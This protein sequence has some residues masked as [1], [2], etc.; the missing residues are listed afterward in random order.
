MNSGIADTA[1]FGPEAEFF[2]LDDIRFDQTPNAGY[3]FLD[4][5]EGEWNRGRDEG[6]NLGYKVR[7]KEGYFPV[8][9]T[10][11]MMDIRNEMMQTLIDCGLA[12]IPGDSILATMIQHVREWCA[13]NGDD[14][15]ATLE[16]TA[17]C[18]AT[19]K[20]GPQA[21]MCTVAEFIRSPQTAAPKTAAWID[22]TAGLRAPRYFKGI[23]TGVS[24]RSRSSNV[25]NWSTDSGRGI[26][27]SAKGTIESKASCAV[28]RPVTC[29][30]PRSQ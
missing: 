30:V 28:Q 16:L 12:Q 15:R 9:P 22:P 17:A 5:V 25:L 18:R 14:W 13:R 24:C 21:R 23:Q 11:H 7:H 8:P 29:C 26:T 3:Y 2:I 4:S 19:P 1:F 6:P 10:D 27:V 20:F